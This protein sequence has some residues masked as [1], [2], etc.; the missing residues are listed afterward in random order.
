MIGIDADMLRELPD[1]DTAENVF[2]DTILYAAD[3]AIPT[4]KG[5]GGRKSPPW[6][7]NAC[8]RAI[9]K[10]KAAWKK[11]KRDSTDDN[12]NNFSRLKAEAQR[13]IRC[14]KRNG[15]NKLISSINSNS[16]TKDVW[17]RINMLQNKHKSELVTTLKIESAKVLVIKGEFDEE[18]VVRI[19]STFGEI[20]EVRA[21]PAM[22]DTPA[23]IT[24]RF[25]SDEEAHRAK[26][27]L[28][29]G[30]YNTLNINATLMGRA[31][32]TIIYDDP[33]DI[34]NCLGR[35]FEFVSSNYNCDEKFNKYR[36]DNESFL[37]FSTTTA[38]GYNV[39]IT[40]KE[41]ET[42]LEAVTDTAPGPD[43][44]HY[45]MLQNLSNGGKLCLLEFLNLIFDS[46]ELPK[47]WK[48]AYIIPILKEGKNPL[49]PD[50]YRPIALTSCIC[51][52]L[53]RI[54]N[55]RLVWFLMKNNLIDKSQTGYQKGKCTLDNLTEL[56]TEIHNAFVKK[57]YLI[58]VFFDLAKAYDTC[59]RHL[60]LQELHRF[61]LRGK[62]P[63]MIVD[64]LED[65]KFQ[66]R[67]GHNLSEVFT[68]EMGVP[69]GSVLST[70][71]FLIAINTVIREIKG[72]VNVSLYV[73]DMR[74]S[75]ASSNLAS[76]TRRMQNC[77]N[78]LDTWTEKTG[79]K[80]SSS[81][82]ETVVFHRQRGLHEDPNPELYLHGKRLKVV[83]EKKFLGVILDHKLQF[84]PHI[85][86]LKARGIKALNILKVIIKNNLRTD[87][88]VLLHIYKALVQSK[89][90][91]ACQ[92]YGTASP[93]ALKML[94]TVH[95]QALRLCT[96]AFRTSPKESLY[97]ETGEQSLEDRRLSLR[98]QFYIRSKQLPVDKTIVHLGDES[99]DH[100]YKRNRN[101]PKSLGFRVRQEVQALDLEVP[102]I[103]I[104]TESKLG[105]WEQPTLE[106]CMALSIFYKNVT[107]AEEFVQNFR[108]HRHDVDIEVYTDGSKSDTGVGAGFGIVS[109]VVGRGF[110]GRRL[111]PMSSVFTA[112][113]Y[114]IKLALLTLRV[115][116]NKS[117][118]VYSDSR[119]ALQA[120]QKL[121][122]T[123]KLVQEI[124][125]LV[126]VLSQ[127]Q[128]AISFCWIPSHVGIEGN[129]LAD[130]AAKLATSN[131]R[132]HRLET[133][134]TDIIAHVKS[135]IKDR[136]QQVW[137][138]IQDNKK[139]RKI[140]STTNKAVFKLSRKD[141][142]KVTRLRIG[143]T[144]LTH[145]YLLVAQE[146]PICVECTW[147]EDDPVY[148]TVEHILLE[149]GNYALDRLPCYEPTNL[150]MK[151]LLSEQKYIYQMI[152]FLHISELYNKI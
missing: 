23:S 38:F 82:T 29:G 40:M 119:S 117:C 57:Q 65:R 9:N 10:R 90:D 95:H 104:L 116:Q 50:S 110:S 61:G 63:L 53:E 150:T 85:K 105:P 111:H 97:V 64:F 120:I 51:K 86:W 102:A 94:D 138:N 125:E 88:K 52:L 83:K 115:Y 93:S 11:Y 71:L 112:E 12:Y 37:N 141:Q 3:K 28:N 42:A 32:D 127:Q 89:L 34:A 148:L 96:G 136:W 33:T 98:V 21:K 4:S 30:Q 113:L 69:Q 56:E 22:N 123:V 134:A 121:G 45:S 80:F 144:R 133:P 66:V 139:L 25:A 2:S 106:V 8:N 19:A 1:I 129:E 14:S 142:M 87:S 75:I 92:I 100:Y 60:I 41:M 74:F 124:C 58:A 118:V 137:F 151:Q 72:Q 79:F 26:E 132:V 84:I 49:S 54:L 131:G 18:E 46:G 152:R 81:K 140:Q 6:W 39:K 122:S 17:R 24:I 48:L 47:K 73:D 67:V 27:Q 36:K 107:T 147:D 101:K 43:G 13:I 135:K 91:Y 31:G 128:V 62:L 126:V 114:A 149:C 20:L 5:S 146:Q 103:S 108:S 35:R 44:I 16:N 68:Q 70:T 78:P 15:W 109:N 130:E 55:R 76:A 7:N 145:G 143:H 59:W 77:L 99:H